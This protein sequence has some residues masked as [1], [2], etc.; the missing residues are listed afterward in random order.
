[1][2]IKY[3]A[4]FALGSLVVMLIEGRWPVLENGI[5]HERFGR[6]VLDG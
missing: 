3:V 4:R 2:I 5:E 6:T 1:M